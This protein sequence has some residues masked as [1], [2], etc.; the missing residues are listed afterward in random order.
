MN[1]KKKIFLGAHCNSYDYTERKIYDFK[2]SKR[3][4]IGMTMMFLLKT[5]NTLKSF[6]TDYWK[7]CLLV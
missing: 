5:M 3:N 6:M 4:I 2:I 1:I 7:V